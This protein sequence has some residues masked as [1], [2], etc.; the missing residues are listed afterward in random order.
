MK[1]TV[2]SF[3]LT[4][5]VLTSVIAT[6]CAPLDESDIEEDVAVAESALLAS[7]NVKGF[8]ATRTSKPALSVERGT[9]TVPNVCPSGWTEIAGSCWESPWHAIGASCGGGKEMD[10]GLC[11]EPCPLGYRGAGPYCWLDVDTI[12]QACDALYDPALSAA[13]M[14]SGRA[15]TFG[16]GA[17]VSAGASLS[18]E[19][20]VYYTES[21]QYGCYT[22]T[23]NGVVTDVGVDMS[24]SFGS[25][26]GVAALTGDGVDLSAGVGYGVGGFTQSIALDEN[27]QVVGFVESV[28]VGVGLSPIA[29][30]AS[31][32]DTVLEQRRAAPIGPADAQ[33]PNPGNTIYRVAPNGSLQMSRHASDGTWD[34]VNR[35]IGW[36]WDAVTQVFAAEGGHVYAIDGDGT[37]VYYHHDSAGNWDNWG[38]EIGWGWGGFAK[39]FVSRFGEIYAIQQDGLLRRYT[40]GA[41]LQFDDDAGT[42][43]GSGWNLPNVFSGGSG[44][45]YNINAEGDLV[46]YYYNGSSWTVAGLEIGQ[47]WGGFATVGSTGN[48]ELYA[49]TQE[50]DVRFYRHDV[51]KVWQFG[52]GAEIGSGW[53]FGATGIIA[54]TY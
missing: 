24:F 40:H 42:V 50:G 4:P 9:G 43:I 52:S 49:V 23:C 28:S 36:G 38:T 39:V 15:L 18:A 20:G 34:I 3:L 13:A 12:G 8:F 46:Y 6:G 37:L 54:A 17:G 35:E 51:N 22:S 1:S 5:F 2:A 10:A 44:A 41:T 7:A 32:C 16:V 11:Y 21:G 48:G 53:D 25:F 26:T 33:D 27:G 29:L 30:G 19:V 47:G 31:T 14:S 45:F